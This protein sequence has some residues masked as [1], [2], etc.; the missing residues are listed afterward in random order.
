LSSR[1][2]GGE[3]ATDE[4]RKKKGLKFQRG[5]R[6]KK[7]G[8]HVTK[9]QIGQQGLCLEKTDFECG[10]INSPESTLEEK[11]TAQGFAKVLGA[12]NLKNLRES[13]RG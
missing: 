1:T 6:R 2:V 4:K 8:N 10:P 12:G 13:Q 5:G 9:K 11:I 7:A 3:E